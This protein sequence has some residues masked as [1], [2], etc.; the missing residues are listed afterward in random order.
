MTTRHASL[1][2][3]RSLIFEIAV[4]TVLLRPVSVTPDSMVSRPSRFRIFRAG[5]LVVALPPTHERLGLL[6]GAAQV[7]VPLQQH[8]TPVQVV[9]AADV[10]HVV[11]APPRQ[12]LE[13]VADERADVAHAVIA[14]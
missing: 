9:V 4:T 8:A 7:V 6:V 10:D 5:E 11:V 12:R 13:R 14:A 2:T 3:G 1:A